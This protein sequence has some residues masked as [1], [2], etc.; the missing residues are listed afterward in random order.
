M[1][2]LSTVCPELSADAAV[3]LLGGDAAAD[4]APAAAAAAS[5]LADG[6]PESPKQTREREDLEHIPQL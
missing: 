1:P 3:D 5:I 2:D 6:K 4:P